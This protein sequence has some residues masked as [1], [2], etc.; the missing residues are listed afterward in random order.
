MRF[1]FERVPRHVLGLRAILGPATHE[2]DNP[3][4]PGAYESMIKNN[5]GTYTMQERLDKSVR[6]NVAPPS[7]KV[8]SDLSNMV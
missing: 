6:C 8:T 7:C 2:S 1:R 3:I 5:G 4:S